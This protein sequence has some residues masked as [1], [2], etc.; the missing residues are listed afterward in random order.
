MFTPAP[1][2]R[3]HRL[4]VV[5]QRDRTTGDVYYILGGNQRFLEGY[6]IKTVSNKS[7]TLLEALPPLDELQK[8]N[9]A[10]QVGGKRG[11]CLGQKGA[12]DMNRHWGTA[13]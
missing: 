3:S 13:G 10:A 7:V 12:V 8:F 4:D 1:Q 6:L 9:A 11:W 5:Q 2:A